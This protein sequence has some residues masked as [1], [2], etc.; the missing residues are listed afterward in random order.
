MWKFIDKSPVAKRRVARKFAKPLI[1]LLSLLLAC[2]TF[3][4]QTSFAEYAQRATAAQPHSAQDAGKAWLSN[5]LAESAATR[6]SLGKTAR[7]KTLLAQSGMSNICQT[8]YG[9]C[10]LPGY[11]AR[12]MQCWCASPQGP[13]GGVVR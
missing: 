5:A 13:I 1:V 10:Y 11:A 6:A 12:G 9:A 3:A 8:P 7:G 4:A 2:A